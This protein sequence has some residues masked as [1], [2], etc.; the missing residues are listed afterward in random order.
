MSTHLLTD[1][2]GVIIKDGIAGVEI[3]R[4]FYTH[5]CGTYYW[6]YVDV[7]F[8]SKGRRLMA[9]PNL[10]RGGEV[11]YEQDLD[12][13]TTIPNPALSWPV[14]TRVMVRNNS[15]DA[16]KCRLLKHIGRLVSCTDMDGET[17]W[18]QQCKLAEGEE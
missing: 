3:S 9:T 7:D 12:E 13:V 2:S 17:S 15:R 16:W 6:R 5:T 14:G 4:R 8:R 10:Y 11:V 18:W 1:V